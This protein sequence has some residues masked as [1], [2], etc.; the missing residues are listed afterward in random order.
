MNEEAKQKPLP[1]V[2][3]C[4]GYKCNCELPLAYFAKNNNMPLLVDTYCVRCN[5]RRRQQRQQER[6]SVSPLVMWIN[7]NNSSKSGSEIKSSI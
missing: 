6:V 1:T 4:P 2:K 5:L 7:M 3:F